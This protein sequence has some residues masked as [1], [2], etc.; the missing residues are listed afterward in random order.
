MDTRLSTRKSKNPL[1]MAIIRGHRLLISVSGLVDF[2]LLQ[3]S[4]GKRSPL[5]ARS[6]G[7]LS[8]WIEDAIG[9]EY[10]LKILDYRQH[11]KYR[12][13]V[14]EDLRPYICTSESCQSSTSTY[15]SRAEYVHHEISQHTYTRGRT[16]ASSFSPTF[17]VFVC[18]CCPTK[19]RKFNTLQELR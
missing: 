9:S 19:P 11:Q 6:V 8:R 7:T 2:L 17:H 15:G 14:L 10:R 3:S 13:H 18:G 4:Y 1:S 16:E 12:K 5:N